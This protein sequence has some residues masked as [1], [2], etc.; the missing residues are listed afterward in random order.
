MP[1]SNKK[2]VL[3]IIVSIKAK[4]VVIVNV[5]SLEEERRRTEWRRVRECDKLFL[6]WKLYKVVF[7]IQRDIGF[8]FIY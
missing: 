1:K 7:C 6:E 3:F 4:S 8:K 5:V 2:C